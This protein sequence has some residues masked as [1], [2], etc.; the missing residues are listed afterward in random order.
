[1]VFGLYP[2]TNEINIAKCST[3]RAWPTSL[4]IVLLTEFVEIEIREP[5]ESR[6]MLRL[7]E[8]RFA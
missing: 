4:G 2:L 7:Q 3:L 6:E 1:M 8:K 5:G